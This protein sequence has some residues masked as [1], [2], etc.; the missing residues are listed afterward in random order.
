MTTVSY[1]QKT[2]RPPRY[3]FLQGDVHVDVAIVGGGIAGISAAYFLKRLG[4]RVALLERDRCLQ[5][6][7]AHTTAHLTYVT[8]T[9][10]SELV[11]NFGEDHAQAVWDA[12]N[13]AI[14]QIHETVHR[15][16]ID[17]DFKWVPGYLHAPIGEGE[18]DIAS[19]Q[20]DAELARKLEFSAEFVDIVPLMARAGVR[21]ANQAKFHPLKYAAALLRRIDG[22]GSFVFEDSEVLEIGEEPIQ[23]KLLTGGC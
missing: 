18:E 8:D 16:D 9:R 21:F 10:L 15:E 13:A 1:W 20:Q 2:E 3:A 6:D 22:D 5:A 4:K 19:F 12:G 11:R 14:H 7:T 23:V 17:C